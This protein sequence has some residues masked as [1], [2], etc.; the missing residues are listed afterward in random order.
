MKVEKE[1]IIKRKEVLRRSM[2]QMIDVSAAEII[3]LERA[4]FMFANSRLLAFII[5]LS[6]F[7][8]FF[9]NSQE[10]AIYLAC[11]M[12]FVFAWLIYRHNS[13]IEKLKKSRAESALAIERL[14]RREENIEGHKDYDKF[15]IKENISHPFLDAPPRDLNNSDSYDIAGE[16][17]HDLDFFTGDANLFSLYNTA[18]TSVGVKKTYN[19]I[20]SPLLKTETIKN[21]Q[22]AVAELANDPVFVQKAMCVLYELRGRKFGEFISALTAPSLLIHNFIFR[23]ALMALALSAIISL[24]AGLYNIFA[25]I[26]VINF[27]LIALFFYKCADIKKNYMSMPFFAGPFYKLSALFYD[28]KFDSSLLRTIAAPL[29]GR[30]KYDDIKNGPP[31]Y[32]KLETLTFIADLMFVPIPV[33][34]DAVFLSELLFCERIERKTN[35]IKN[36]LFEFID[37]LAELEALISFANIKID[38]P[39]Y[40]FAVIRDIHEIKDGKGFIKINDIVHPLIKYE[41]AVENSITFDDTL[42]I[43]IVTGSNMSGKSTLLKSIAIS[44]ILSLAGAPVRARELELT[45]FVVIT[46]IRITDSIKAGVSHFYSELLRVK[47][48]T[49]R[50]SGPHKVFA[51]FDELFHGTNNR[52]R[53]AL[54]RATL[55]YLRDSGGKFIMATHDGELTGLG[56]TA[57]APEVGNFHLEEKTAA[58]ESLESVFTYR[59]L[60]GPVT[61]VNAIKLA[62]KCGLPEKIYKRA[63]EIAEHKVS[64]DR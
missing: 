54:C 36:E 27:V 3:R 31:F 21:R 47:A 61:V 2:Q 64:R 26:Y 10:A 41:N 50:L 58:A 42:D 33:I 39:E 7:W 44:V 19:Y 25:V 12:I 5:L 11:I 18:Q 8:L 22:S 49:D 59:L 32:K 48:V 4:D 63:A 43:A 34:L 9:N 38:L 51:I 55:E 17:L 52:E 37:A 45:P 62:R 14:K 16:I 57:E 60:K 24:A 56:D 46:D 6:C 29:C 40:N 53:V 1:E 23:L 15:F 35:E 30:K 28:K 13:V 20:K